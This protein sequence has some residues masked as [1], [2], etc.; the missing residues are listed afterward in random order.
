MRRALL[1]G[2]AATAVVVGTLTPALAQTDE[3]RCSPTRENVPVCSTDGSVATA[4]FLDPTVTV[5]GARHVGL[6][7]R[8]YVG[9][10][11]ELH[12]TRHA[13]ISVGASSNVQ[14]NVL[15]DARGGSGIRV[16]DRVILAHGSSV[17]GSASVGIES[18]P[19][20]PQVA[21]TVDTLEGSV[22]L[23]FG[24]E[25]DGATV[26]IDS[27]VSAL[28]RVAPG[29]TLPSG[30]LV[31]PG[32]NVTTDAEASDPA[33]GKVRYL[34][35]ADVA[36]NEAVIHVNESL[37]RAYTELYR[38]DP[39]AVHGVNLDPGHT[40]FNPDADLPSFAG[41][42][43]ARPDSRNRVIGDVDLADTYDRFTQRTGERIAIRADEGEPF[44]VGHVDEMDDD[45]V[46]HAL[47]HTD[48]HVGDDVRYGE[49]AIVHGGGRV[50]VEGQPEEQTVVGDRVRLGDGSVVF[51]STIGDGARIGDR[52]GV[53]GTDL[54]A[55]TVVPPDTIVLNGEVF[56]AVE[57]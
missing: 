4:T 15:L 9:P 56:G 54:P 18:S 16:G 35:Q 24:S 12:A 11:A 37:A 51:R 29:V 25:V 28:A 44:V 14:D 10:F 40:E 33:L 27:G 5:T 21:G 57:W 6:G 22:F 19:L 1:T 8:G 43:Q 13:P 32:K 49:G 23:S 31:L 17:R 45:V 34:T 38:E 52:S 48:V 55:G 30:F 53:V 39:G 36:F 26:E 7:Q 41:D 46:F 42:E 3:R 50:V 2:S 47:E 20:P